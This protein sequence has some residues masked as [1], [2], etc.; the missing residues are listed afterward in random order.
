MLTFFVVSEPTKYIVEVHLP[1]ARP[2]K[3]EV[4]GLFPYVDHHGVILRMVLHDD[5]RIA[6]Y[7]ASTFKPE[8][9]TR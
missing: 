8:P 7:P 6:Y 5:G 1:G 3:R 9:P 4:S 2:V